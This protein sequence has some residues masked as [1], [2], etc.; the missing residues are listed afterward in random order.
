MHRFSI[1]HSMSFEIEAGMTEL[2]LNGSNPV[3]MSAASVSEWVERCGMGG[4]EA[5]MSEDMDGRALCFLYDA[6]IRSSICTHTIR[7]EI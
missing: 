2:G 5:L 3:T 7:Q 1:R 4:C 6:Y